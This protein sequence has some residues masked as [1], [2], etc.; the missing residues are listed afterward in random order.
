MSE[1][2]T[3]SSV[4][5][6]VVSHQEDSGRVSHLAFRTPPNTEEEDDSDY[7]DAD[8]LLAM[9]LG[10]YPSEETYGQDDRTLYSAATGAEFDKK[11]DIAALSDFSDES[12]EPPAGTKSWFMKLM[13][14]TGPLDGAWTRWDYGTLPEI[15][16]PAFAHMIDSMLEQRLAHDADPRLDRYYP[17]LVQSLAK[18]MRMSVNMWAE[19]DNRLN[20]EGRICTATDCRCSMRTEMVIRTF[21]KEMV[22]VDLVSA[23]FPDRH[24]RKLMMGLNGSEIQEEVPGTYTPPIR[25]RRGRKYASLRK[26]ETDVEDYFSCSEE[27]EVWVD[28]TYSWY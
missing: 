25:R 4:H 15:P 20:E 6:T 1:N 9:K 21:H 2:S 12:S 27:E 24:V 26:Y 16:D 7:S 17:K 19:H 8:G 23:R 28:R 11:A 18:A 22:S 3:D 10:G 5:H 14:D 13:W